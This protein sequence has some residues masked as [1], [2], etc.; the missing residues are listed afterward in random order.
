MKWVQILSDTSKMTLKGLKNAF[1]IVIQL[2]FRSFMFFGG[3]KKSLEET[4]DLGEWGN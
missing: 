3:I 2:F 4:W 1:T